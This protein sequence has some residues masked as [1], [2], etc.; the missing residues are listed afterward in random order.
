MVFITFLSCI[1]N[2]VTICVVHKVTK[3]TQTMNLAQTARDLHR[4][5]SKLKNFEL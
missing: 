3:V 4:A 1:V 2:I 5:Y